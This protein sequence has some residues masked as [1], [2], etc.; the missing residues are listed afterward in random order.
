MVGIN[1]IHTTI[2]VKFFLKTWR[3]LFGD[4]LDF[5]IR[6]FNTIGTVG[7]LASL[8]GVIVDFANG[9]GFFNVAICTATGTVSIWALWYSATTGKYRTGYLILIVFNFMCCFPAL[10]LSSGG[11]HS[12]MPI[13]FILAMLFTIFLLEGKTMF[14]M[15][16]AE[17]VLYTALFLY[18]YY[19]PENI[20]LLDSEAKIFTDIFSCFL[21]ASIILSV[22]LLM[23]LRLY[24]RRQRE[25]VA[26]HKQVEDYAKMK[27]E[28]FAEM[29]HEIRTPLTVMST[30]AQYTVEQLRESGADEQTLADLATISDEAKRLAEMADGTLKVLMS[31]PK[32]EG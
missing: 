10:Y 19:K 31:S 29:C 32:T 26:M 27:S 8:T 20:K 28:M 2:M 18:A 11:Y 24:D 13:Y 5:R 1:Y 17:Q 21:A 3:K 14:I 7:I 25:L 23:H 12:G 15:V 6:L 9:L 22:T 16:A 30:H 4:Q